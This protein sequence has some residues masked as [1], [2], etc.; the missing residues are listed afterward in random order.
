MGYNP[1]NFAYHVGIGPRVP[2][3]AVGYAIS[4]FDATTGPEDDVL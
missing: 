3:Y 1:A 2:G 4:F